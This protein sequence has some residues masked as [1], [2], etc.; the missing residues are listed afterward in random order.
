MQQQQVASLHPTVADVL[1]QAN[2][3]GG[4]AAVITQRALQVWANALLAQR[5]VLLPSG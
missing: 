3:S 1:S 2:N 5:L 4:H